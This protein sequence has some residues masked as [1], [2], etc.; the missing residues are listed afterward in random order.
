MNFIERMHESLDTAASRPLILEVKGKQLVETTGAQLKQLVLSARGLLA[1]RGIQPG[2]RVGLIAHNAARWA[3]ADLA[4]LGAGAICVPMYD[5]QAVNEL[6]GMLS[7]CDAALVLVDTAKLR[8]EL[9]AVFHADRIV[10]FDELFAHAQIAT[11]PRTRSKDDRAT[12]IYT[13]GTS[14]EPKGVLYTVENVD[15]MLAQTLAGIEAMVAPRTGEDRVF[16]YLP[17]CFAGSRIQLWSQ[18][19]RA[20]PLMVSTD[21]NNLVEELGTAQPNYFL[22]VPTLLERIKTGVGNKLKE[23]GG[24]AYKLYSNA[25]AAYLKPNRSLADKLAL[26][27]GERLV[28]PK[29]RQQIGKNLEFLI[30]GSAPLSEETQR[31]F[32]MIGIPAYQVYGL[33]ETTAIV[34]M[35][36]KGVARPGYVGRPLDGVQVK[37]SDEGE[38]LVRGPNIFPEYWNRPDATATSLRDGWFH[39]GDMCEL[40]PDQDLRIVGRLK[41]LLVPESGH[42]VAPGPLEEKLANA[43][44]GAQVMLVGHARPFL[45]AIFAGVKDDGAVQAAIDGLNADLPHYR[46][47]RKYYLAPE[48]FSVENGLLTANQKLKRNAVEKHYASQIEGLYS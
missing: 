20:N 22:N 37:I 6:A 47:V 4:I 7:N 13:S 34:T 25:V 24:I 16:H 10:T 35:D 23:R 31:W 21:L 39:T 30:C 18:L 38:L 14:G 28:F 36:K 8:D 27:V 29:I 40:T 17:F 41:D 32:N 9:G 11:K 45:T 19:A 43:L 2:D 44:P 42:N 15:F 26:A 33:T 1:A 3:A 12:M 48:P 5:R 46:R